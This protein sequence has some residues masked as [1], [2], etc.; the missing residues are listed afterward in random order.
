MYRLFYNRN[1]E[2]DDKLENY[3]FWESGSESKKTQSQ[4]QDERKLRGNRKKG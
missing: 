4:I 2:N 1:D 3:I